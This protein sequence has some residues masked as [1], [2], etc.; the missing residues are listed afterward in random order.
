[1]R[2]YPFMNMTVLKEKESAVWLALVFQTLVVHF[3]DLWSPPPWLALQRVFRLLIWAIST[4]HLLACKLY[5][6][7]DNVLRVPDL[8]L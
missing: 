4:L 1:M 7:A 2:A 3:L 8:L 6:A 5:V